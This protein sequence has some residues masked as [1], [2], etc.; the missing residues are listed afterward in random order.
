MAGSGNFE[1]YKMKWTR[2]TIKNEAESKWPMIE[3]FSI[4]MEKQ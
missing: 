2:L 1:T 3:L 4:Y